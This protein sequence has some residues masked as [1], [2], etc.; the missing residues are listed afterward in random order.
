MKRIFS[1][2][3]GF[4]VLTGVGSSTA[5]SQAMQVA[6]PPK[7]VRVERH[8]VSR[9]HGREPVAALKRGRD[10]L[11]RTVAQDRQARGLS[12]RRRRYAAVASGTGCL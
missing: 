7:L 1:T 4:L 11:L 12:L 2:I 8:E 9:V 5:W 3:I 6:K 10:L